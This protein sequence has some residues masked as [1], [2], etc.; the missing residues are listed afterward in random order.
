VPVEWKRLG[1]PDASPTRWRAEL[2]ADLAEARP[3][4]SPRP[5]RSARAIRAV[6]AATLGRERGLVSEPTPQKKRRRVWPWI[7][8]PSS[9]RLR[10]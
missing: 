2:E 7:V 8:L 6:F 9:S 3:T 1:V 4:A 5:D 10:R